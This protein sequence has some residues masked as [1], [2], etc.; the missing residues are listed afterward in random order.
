MLTLNENTHFITTDEVL[1]P[2]AWNHVA[3]S[4]DG[5]TWFVYVDGQEV[6]QFNVAGQ[7]PADGQGFEIGR[8]A[9]DIGLNLQ[10]VDVLYAWNPYASRPTIGIDLQLDDGSQQ[11]VWEQT[12]VTDGDVYPLTVA[13]RY[14]RNASIEMRYQFQFFG[15]ESLGSVA[16]NGANLHQ[17]EDYT[18]YE[19]STIHTVLL[20]ENEI[21]S[22]PFEGEIDEVA[23]YK[24]A[25]SPD[26]ITDLYDAGRQV[27]HLPLNDAPG[28]SDFADATGQHNGACSGGGCPT[29]GVPGR[30]EMALRFDGVD[31]VVTI[32]NANTADLKD[33]TLA[34]WVKLNST[35]SGIMRFITVGDE[36][37][38]LRYENGD[39]HFY[40]RTA[41]GAFHHLRHGGLQADTWYHVV[42]TY[43]GSQMRL[44]LDGA[45]V[46]IQPVSGALAGGDT[47]K[48]SHSDETLDGLLDEVI[49][50]RQSLS[51]SDVQTLFNRP[52]EM[53]L[54]LD[55]EG[56]TA[57][58]ADITGNGHD[59]T[60]NGGHCPDAGVKGQIGPAQGS[61]PEAEF[62][63]VGDELDAFA[64]FIG[65][66][67]P[68]FIRRDL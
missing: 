51:D 47:I 1:T 24:T 10:R 34:A 59:G 29:A 17:R 58:F 19:N 50:Y 64:L 44:Y 66:A 37:A 57:A 49:V 6:E 46:E 21:D 36:K 8:A 25:L 2:D 45:Q 41:D 55:E 15:D 53:L 35:P 48:L 23:I 65:D 26:D 42:G 60:C 27:V 7:S 9:E 43:D 12:N 5:S 38:V 32:E 13:Q 18:H 14:A 52:P 56:Q 33:I 68:N 20:W 16:F 3:A 4:F 54:S 40:I 22:S 11:R 31:D 61:L 62:V 28:A 67:N 63:L 30:D 39:L